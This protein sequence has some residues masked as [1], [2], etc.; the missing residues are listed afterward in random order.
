MPIAPA[1]DRQ[2]RAR[3]PEET[4]IKK[5]AC[6]VTRSGGLKVGRRDQ[7]TSAGARSAVAGAAWN[8]TRGTAKTRG[9]EWS[10]SRLSPPSQQ[11]RASA[12]SDALSQQLFPSPQPESSPSISMSIDP[13][14]DIPAQQATWADIPTG[15]TAK[16]TRTRRSL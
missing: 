8:T 11:W 5:A 15:I 13:I 10:R 4:Q 3:I 12:S 14:D 2:E 16:A 7:P 1:D 9:S 6:R